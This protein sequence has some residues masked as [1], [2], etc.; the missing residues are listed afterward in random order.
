MKTN[1]ETALQEQRLK[2]ALRL[3]EIKATD[4]ED[5]EHCVSDMQKSASL[6]EDQARIVAAAVRAKHLPNIL[7]EAGLYM[8]DE[9]PLK[10]VDLGTE[11]AGF[12]EDTTDETH[13]EAGAEFVETE[14]FDSLN[15]TE[16]SDDDMGEA[17]DETNIATFQIEVPADMVEVAQQAVQKALDEALGGDTSADDADEEDADAAFDGLADDDA[18]ADL[19]G[20]KDTEVSDSVEEVEETTPQ[21]TASKV[22]TMTKEA[23]EQRR[24][25][26]K[27]LLQRVVV[28]EEAAKPKYRGLGKDTTEGTY[29]GKK[30]KPFQY[31]GEAQYHCEKDYPTM[32]L[33]GGEGNSQRGENPTYANQP[34]PTMNP[35]NL[36]LKGAVEAVKLDGTPDGTLEYVIDFD[37]LNDVPSADADCGPAFEIPTQME[38]LPRKTTVA[39]ASDTEERLAEVEDV[40]YNYLVKAGVDGEEVGKM[41]VAQGVHLLMKVAAA[42]A[43]ETKA[44]DLNVEINA[45]DAKEE[46]KAAVRESRIK[47][48]FACAY[49][50]ASQ[51]LLPAGEIEGYAETM[52]NDGLTADS[53]I[54]QT[55]LLMRSAKN[56]AERVVAAAAEKFGNVRTAYSQVVSSSPALS[57]GQPAN[58]ATLDI[59]EALRGVFTMPRVDED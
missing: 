3:A 25:E 29:G 21:H 15:S 13:D 38:N 14:D 2:A 10:V 8:L 23:K 45:D 54:R 46:R 27:A 44:N 55:S 40:V 31:D 26:R 30:A 1:N 32:S 33:K 12:A 11:T 58:S 17:I 50:L 53:M 52:L 41:T 35:E 22:N 43:E 47:T 20:D 9:E 51:G 6:E 7:R 57:G 56:N 42:K 4:Q 39:S 16:D 59:Q 5:M 18:D 28:A 24:A 34:I 49:N 36:Q 19:D 48:A 37:K